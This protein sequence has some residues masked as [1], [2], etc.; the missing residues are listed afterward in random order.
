VCFVFACLKISHAC[1]STRALSSISF[2]LLQLLSE[3]LTESSAATLRNYYAPSNPAVA[4]AAA[5]HS[6]AAQAAAAKEADDSSSSS[7]KRPL[8][9]PSGNTMVDGS[10]NDSGAM[11]HD[12]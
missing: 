4:A 3:Y 6:A 5:S 10:T 1:V 8:A 9:D 7:S 11:C 2:S 12:S